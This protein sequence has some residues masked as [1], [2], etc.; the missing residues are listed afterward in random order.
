MANNQDQIN[1]LLEKLDAL[2]KKQQ[3]FS[4]EIKNLKEE[5]YT[6]KASE[7][8]P[9]VT[10]EK[11]EKGTLDSVVQETALEEETNQTIEEQVL[12]IKQEAI[13]PNTPSVI[14]KKDKTRSNLEKFIGENLINKIGIIITIIGVA[15]GAKY[16][17]ER[18]LISPLTR[19]ILG[20]LAGVG[21]LLVGMKLKKKYHSYSAVL[22]SGAMTILYFI[23]FLAYNLYDLIPQVFAFGLMVVFTIFTVVAAIHY[24]K[25]IIAHIGLVG[26]YA[27][28]FLL[29]DGSGNFV[30]LFSYM[31]IIN[32][33]VLIIAMLKYWKS[34]YISSFILTWLIYFSWY[35]F[36]YSTEEHFTGAF[37]FLIIFFVTFYLMFLM[38]K[39]KRKEKFD[40]GD[41]ILQLSNSFIFYGIGFSMLNDH[42]TGKELLGIYT[43]VN[44][45][46]H[47]IVSIT[48]Y[49]LKLADKNLFYFVS[50]MVLVFITIAFPVQLDGNWV[51]LLWAGEAALLFWIGRTKKV[52]IYEKLSYPLIWLAF[53]SLLHDWTT[54]YNGYIPDVPGSGVFPIFNINMLTSIGC[55]TSFWFI[56]TIHR[57]KNF[58]FPWPNL[59]WW[60]KML[61]IGLV[62]LLI[63]TIYF[64][65]RIE[66]A[67]YWNQV[68]ADIDVLSINNTDSDYTFSIYDQ[69]NDIRDFKAIWLINY[70]LLFL[71]IVSFINIK[72]IKDSVFGYVTLIVNLLMTLFFLT[73]G[74][75]LL[76]ELRE[77]Y[78]EQQ[79][80][81][82]NQSTI[83]HLGIRYI[84]LAF[85]TLFLFVFYKYV[86]QK[87]L[88]RTFI[89]AFDFVLHISILWIISSELIHWLDMGESTK[90]YKLALSILWGI[91]ALFLIVLGIWKKKKYLRIMAIILFG[92][93]LLK[94]FLYDISHLE[95]IP[96]TIVF[97]SLG[98]L[99]LI[100]SFLYNKYKHI[101]ADDQEN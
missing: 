69:L 66:I 57:N 42:E 19:I 76:S 82:F 29:S 28:P 74:L 8:D 59:Q 17:I 11:N 9:V 98:I 46:I 62:F 75:Y 31:A 10:D 1:H 3:D 44:A 89:M 23:T 58:S 70:T 95:T 77:S 93:T 49:R 101:I 65:F 85:I 14:K 90:A 56:Y 81:E 34:L 26:A 61:T 48:V 13:S 27:V 87:F 36:E 37:V 32:V 60:Y 24:N 18:D 50:G 41:L 39:L 73:R 99:L 47:F 21:L 43:L 67:T 79:V 51:T 97:L 12:P 33:G 100:I 55:I 7:K 6:L 30:I 71:I 45:I 63:T 5:I 52:P 22:V 54:V 94:L 86:R 92:I 68:Y 96:K 84:S 2:L 91:Y 83:F 72:K 16:S 40:I 15:I 25:Q 35:A 20:Y 64:A 78:L 38:Y 80:S 88:H 4:T 53:F